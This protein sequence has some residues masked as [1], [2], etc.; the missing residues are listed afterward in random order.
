MRLRINEHLEAVGRVIIREDK[1]F[2]FLAYLLHGDKNVLIDTVP[3]RSATMLLES[4]QEILGTKRLDAIIANHSEQ[5]H[6]GALPIILAAYKGVPVYGTANCQRRLG[7]IVPASDFHIVHTGDTLQI[8]SY[9]FSFTETPGLHWDDNMV[10]FLEE[11]GILFSNDLFG[12]AAAADPCLD[13][14]YTQEDLLK[15]VETY[16]NNVFAAAPLAQKQVLKNIATLPIKFIAPGHGVVL[17][18][19]SQD[20]LK[21]YLSK[22]SE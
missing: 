2:S 16:Y 17:Q 6:S 15:A 19:H 9:K 1:R 20:V 8:G 4:L 14:E 5:D 12:Q 11:E 18:R 21:Y 22:L 13:R 7:A 3:E 10:T